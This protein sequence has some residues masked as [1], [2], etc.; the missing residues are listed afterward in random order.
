VTA[1]R[2]GLGVRYAYVVVFFVIA[3]F[4]LLVLTSTIGWTF[5]TRKSVAAFFVIPVSLVLLGF[6]AFGKAF[7]GRLTLVL[8]T[9]AFGF[10]PAIAS[11]AWARIEAPI[12]SAAQAEEPDGVLSFFVA[13]GLVLAIAGAAPHV[14]DI[15]RGLDRIVRIVA[16][17][18]VVAEIAMFAVAIAHARRPDPDTFIASLP[19]PR[20]LAFNDQIAIGGTRLHYVRDGTLRD[21][22]HVIDKTFTAY[23]ASHGCSEKTVMVTMDD[24]TGIVMVK[25]GSP[26][27]SS[28][29]L[30]PPEIARRLAAPVGWTHLAGGGALLAAIALLLASAF[31]RRARAV[32]DPKETPPTGYRVPA[33]MPMD[34]YAH[35]RLRD[36]Y[37]A[38]ARGAR[39]VALTIAAASA[40]PLAA[41]LAHRVGL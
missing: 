36:V 3:T 22:C 11:A 38:R 15:E 29:A 2:S 4:Y 27:S 12:V 16:P 32:E 37:E 5:D 23:T 10:V 20:P 7:E 21:A 9:G 41:A 1:T 39:A 34:E 40:L 25:K 13:L 17:I 33:P 28:K 8:A 14:V 30:R 19:E 6:A 18:L 26:W 35:V 31:T 24:V